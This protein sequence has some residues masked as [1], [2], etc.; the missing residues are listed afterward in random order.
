MSTGGRIGLTL[1]LLIFFAAGVFFLVMLV[2]QL[3]RTA[4]TYAWSEIGCTIRDSRAV[5]KDQADEPYWFEVRYTYAVDGTAYTSETYQHGYSGSDDY[6]AALRLAHR[7]PKGAEATCYVNPADPEDAIL[8]Q[9]GLWAVLIVPLPLLFIAV[10]AGGIYFTWRGRKRKAGGAE[11]AESISAKA[12]TG[13]LAWVLIPF[14]GVFFVAGAGFLYVAFI[15]PA[16]KIQAA[17]DWVETPCTILFSDIR[18]HEGDESTTYSLDIFYAYTVDG[19]EYKSSRYSFSTGSSS[20]YEWRQKE[21]D[22]YRR[23]KPAV[24]YVDPDDPYEAVLNRGFTP[25]TWFGLI[26]GVFVLAG[27]IGMF[28]STRHVLRTRA[29]VAAPSAFPG[30]FPGAPTAPAAGLPARAESAGAV[31]LKPK[32]SPLTKLVITIL[33]AAFW[34]G[35]VSVF[36]VQAVRGWAEGEAPWFLTLFLVPFVLVGLGMLGAIGYFFLALFN[37]RPTL[38]VSSSAVPLGGAVELRWELDGQVHRVRRL[39]IALK[40]REEAEY[41]RGTTTVTDREDFARLPIAA[42]TDPLGMTRGETAFT[43]PADTVHSFESENNKIVWH[44][45][46]HGDIRMWPDV[47]EEFA[48]TVLPAS[49]AEEAGG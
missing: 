14:F 21:R 12:K 19:V 30:A 1:F 45:C 41:Q 23:D 33:V 2:G 10:G 36:L 43:I 44:L 4:D 24:C 5:R 31:T 49:L 28:F 48:F 38:R 25:D 7:Y 42:V 11:G 17:E 22:R 15:R 20:S 37:P 47:K 16:I 6:T 32:Q 13:K 27:A 40:G 3:R 35:I 39:D 8:E 34:N 9:E 26:P 18:S 29:A 46:V